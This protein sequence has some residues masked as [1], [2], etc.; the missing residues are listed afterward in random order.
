MKASKEM[1]ILGLLQVVAAA[2]A[3]AAI[4]LLVL[5]LLEPKTGDGPVSNSV[6]DLNIPTIVV[7]TPYCALQYPQQWEEQIR[8]KES[9]TFG[10]L[11]KEF[12]AIIAE[13]EYPLYTVYFGDSPVGDLFGYL[14]RKN[15]T[16]SVYIACHSLTDGT[17]LPEEELLQYYLMMETV[18][19]VSQSIA[20]TPG[21]RN[22]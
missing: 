6:P 16:V 20:L 1:K 17:T 22:S 11:A 13:K 8:V 12:C 5:L 18:N 15:D 19:T 14:S 10:V 9:E 3:L 7:E 21:Y 2:V 4:V